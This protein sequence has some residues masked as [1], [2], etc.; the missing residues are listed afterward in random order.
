MMRLAVMCLLSVS[1]VSASCADAPAEGEGDVGEGEGDAGEGEGDTGEGEGDAGEGEG[2]TGE[3]EGEGDVGEGEGEVVWPPPLTGDENVGLATTQTFQF[4]E[5]PAFDV[6]NNRLLFSDI[7]ANT[8][9]ALDRNSGAVTS[10]LSPS[11]NANGL[12]FARDGALLVCEHSGRQISRRGSDGVPTTLVDSFE[13][14]RLNS[15]ND[16][17]V[18]DNGNIYFTDPPYGGNPAELDFRGVFLLRE[19]G[20][21]V[22]L[23]R[24]FTAPN[25][26]ALSPDGTKLY[27]GDS[28]DGFVDTFDVGPDGLV[29][30]R[31]AFVPAIQNPDGFAMDLAGDLYIAAGDGVHVVDPSGVELGTIAPNRAS[32]V[33]FGGPDNRTLYTTAGDEVYSVVLQVP[34]L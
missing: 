15:P 27:V 24:T 6:V 8:I 34:G 9:Y 2:D 22:A 29:S 28:E 23:D 5:G 17:V 13:G 32:N 30:N 18:D 10:F 20:S 26:I 3:G 19:D 33:G 31:T 4:V 16:L 1:F 21:V 7:P 11:N 14:N 25:G 12:A